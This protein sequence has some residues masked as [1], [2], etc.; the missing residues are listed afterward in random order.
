MLGPQFT[1]NKSNTPIS[2]M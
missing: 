1:I 2:C